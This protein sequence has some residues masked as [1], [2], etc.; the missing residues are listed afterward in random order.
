MKEKIWSFFFIFG[1]LFS[2]VCQA[3]VMPEPNSLAFKSSSI[4]NSLPSKD[5]QSVYQ[6]RDGYIW[7][8]TRNGLFQYDGY[9][10]TTYKSNLYRPDLLTNN[11]IYCVAEDAQHRLWIGTYSGLNVLDKQ[12]GQIW[13]I[14]D[15]EINGIGISQILVT[16]DNRILFATEGGLLEYLEDGNRF[17]VFNQDNTG[18]VFPKTTV[19]SLFEDDRGDIWIGTWS[20]G[21]FR[22]EK[23]TGEYWKYP[24]MNSGN[25]AHVVFQDSHKNIWVGTWGAGLHLLHDAYNPE[26]TTWTTFTHDENRSGT[27]S[28]NLIYAISEDLNTNSLWVG[29]R[30][31]LSI[32]S[33][34]DMEMLH[35]SFEN[36]YSGESENSITSSEVAS[37]LRDRQG[38]MW[39]GMIGGGVNMANTRKAKFNLDRLSEAK[40]I[41]KSNSVRSILLDDEG[42]LWMGISTYG[43][44]VEDR[45]TGKF[46][47]HG[48][49]PDFSSYRGISTVMSI[50][51]SPSTGHIW[52]GVYNG[53]AYEIDKSAPVGKRVKAYN[54]SNAPWM[55]NSCIYYICEDSK[56]NLWFATKS[57]VSMRAADGTPVRF[58]SLKVG[59][60]A[61]R[62]M[63]VMQ[64]VEGHDSEMWLASNTHGVIRIQGSGNS[65]SGYTFSGY[66][67]S[68][69]KLNSDYANCIYKDVEGRIWVGTGGSGLSLY[70]AVEDVFL[71][72]HKLWNL[73]GD[74]VTNI[75]S[76]KK[77]NLWL[78]T[79]AGLLRLTVP[80]D[81]QNVT[82]RLYTTSDGLQD[83]IFNRGASFV[84]SDGEMFFGGHRGY[85]SFYPDKQDEQVFSSPVVITDIKVFNQSWTALSDKERSEISNLSPRFTDKIVLD[86]KRNN[87]SIEFSALEYANPE[88]NRYAYRL[89]GFD[90]GWQYTDASKR[91][92]YYNNLKSGTYTFYVK[93][94]NSN[95]IWDENIQ[96]VKVVILPPPWKTWWAYTLYIIVLLGISWY[97]YRIVRNRIRLR[98]ALHLREMEQAKSEEINHA[99]LQFFTNITHELLT[100]LTI[101]SASVDEL[102]QTAPAYKEQYDVMTHNINR[103]IRLLQ[104]ILEFRKAETGNL[105]LKVL[106]GDL[107]LFV[108][109]S[110]DGFRPLMKKKDIR[111]TIQSDADKCLAF[112]DPDKLDKIL[113]NLLSNASKYNKPG[114]KVGIELN[115]DEVNGIACIIVKDNG[116]GIP[117]ESQK[118][119]FKRFYEGDY[120][121]FNTIGT[122]IGLSLVRDLVTLH[123]GSIS[124]ESEE[125]KGA[126]FK[127]QFPV[128]RFAYSEDEIDDAVTLLDSDGIDAVQEDVVITDAQADIL[129]ENLIPVEQ[130]VA[131]KSHTLLLVEDNEDLLGL[132]VKLLGGDYTIHTAT[133]GKEALEVVELEDI[134][135]IVSDVMMPVMDGIEFCRNIKGNF[136]TSHI[137]LILLTAKKQEEDRVEAYESGADAFITKPFN[138]SVLHARIGNLLKSRER[139]MKD[140][141]KQLVFEAKELNYTSMDEDFLQRAIDCVNRHLDDPNFDQ[142]QFLEEMN[143]TKS[144]FFRKLKSLT[145]LTYVSFIRNIRMKAAC[146]IMEEKK[147]VRISELAYAV[148][149]N[150]PRYFSSIFKKEIGMQPSEYME[151][152]TS[153]GTIEGE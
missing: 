28:D 34:R 14:D 89:D 130:S 152:F 51:Q 74:A 37:L 108:R 113:Y 112:F 134:D 19:K 3:M 73:P 146:R 142:T 59:D 88:R 35:W 25:S 15:P 52:I 31:G 118:N 16:S 32:L 141:K 5:V 132:M 83:N 61:V 60:V 90:A 101:I 20:Q 92:A 99:K 17:S 78:G 109:R 44:G 144:T 4:L 54:S 49:M 123:H 26:K 8:S 18:G 86:Y 103:L 62:D 79:N 12:T 36:C 147:H 10:I 50:M 2:M 29:T 23:R 70:D 42:Q 137:P 120:R 127:I 65:L 140:F 77:G 139:V 102:K 87:F 39:V 105:K 124:V 72:A 27:I 96:T 100:P 58:D 106:Q 148:G 85:N 40:R 143:T 98:N 116:P 22:Y 114:G 66:S 76:D 53:G 150:D 24:Q 93:S 97:I 30:S 45:R 71:P 95:G 6:D 126:A 110:L 94:S 46:T 68:N 47:H 81:L 121:K 9:S 7:I 117:K 48:Q 21:L 1:V 119:L 111:F 133:N 125:G 115:C 67:V 136:D 131:E 151:R 55:C 107:V 80:R 43:F 128:H 33:L 104:Q 63:V 129:E 138:L 11:N 153:G 57:G 82:Y 149:Y 91:F 69:G 38:I 64:L 145:G 56:Q 84:A 122:G 75:Q 135:L 13:K 41:L